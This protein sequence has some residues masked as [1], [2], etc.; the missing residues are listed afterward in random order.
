MKLVLLYMLYNVSVQIHWPFL[1]SHSPFPHCN[2]WS[3][4]PQFMSWNHLLPWLPCSLPWPGFSQPLIFWL[5]LLS[6]LH[7]FFFYF[8]FLTHGHYLRW[9]QF[10]SLSSKSVP[11]YGDGFQICVFKPPVSLLISSLYLLFIWI[12]SYSVLPRFETF[13]IIFDVFP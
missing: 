12:P 13:E 10:P 2:S 5:F 9:Y 6:F 4:W 11:I 3:C 1:C 8:L 7:E